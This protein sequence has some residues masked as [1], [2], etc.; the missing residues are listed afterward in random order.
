MRVLVFLFSIFLSGISFSQTFP[1]KPIRLVVGYPPGGSADFTGRIIADELS[2]ELGGAAV[3]V[4][5]R[6]GAGG[7]IASE[8]VAKSAPDGYTVLNQVNHA[9]NRNLYKQLSYDDKDFIPVISVASGANVMVVNNATPFQNLKELIDYARAH[10]GKLFNASAGFGSAPH[11]ATCAFEAVAGVKVTSVQFKGGGPAA[12]ALLAGD[13]Q[14]MIATAPT[15][16]GFVKGGR[17][18]ALVVSASQ[19]SPSIPGIPGG[20]AAGL[21]GF[22]SAVWFGLYVPA[23]TPLEIV[24]RLHAAAAKGLSKTDTREKFA[25]QGMDA[26]PSASPEAFAAEL[27]AEAQ[28]I[29]RA[30]K[31]CGAKVE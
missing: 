4:E 23:G 21:P 27:R 2:K 3:V 10:P 18:R 5:N 17:M 20:D 13:T 24:R 11:L 7:S 6:A 16:M 30:L 1:S 29:E 19:G 26:R 12:L 9:I 22:D 25:L 15:V 28:Q 8:F 14:M 31:N